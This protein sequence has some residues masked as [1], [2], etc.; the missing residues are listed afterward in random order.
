MLAISHPGPILP[1]LQGL[2]WQN[3]DLADFAP[4]FI[5]HTLLYLEFEPG[6][7]ELCSVL[8]RVQSSAPQL[9]WLVLSSVEHQLN[10]SNN[11][12]FTQTLVSLHH[13]MGLDFDHVPL[14]SEA[15]LH[16][17]RLPLFVSLSLLLLEHSEEPWNSSS[18]GGFPT[19]ESLSLMPDEE[20]GFIVPPAPFLRALSGASLIKLDIK[21][22]PTVRPGEFS[23]LVSAIGHLRR[24]KF[25]DI[26]F[27]QQDVGEWQG[28]IIDGAALSP[29]YAIPCIRIFQMTNA[30]VRI[31]PGTIR[32]LGRAWKDVHELTFIPPSPTHCHLHLEDLASF[33][34]NFHTLVDLTIQVHPITE[35]DTWGRTAKLFLPPS[36]LSNL[37]LSKSR[38]SRPAEAR[39]AHY[40]ARLFPFARVHHSF[41]LRSWGGREIAAEDVEA[42]AVL[43]NVDRLKQGLKEDVLSRSFA[44]EKLKRAADISDSSGLTDE[45]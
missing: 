2:T 12:V 39:V 40:L 11:V 32:E 5:R 42:V 6:G 25:L 41:N 35:P 24:L 1:R 37:H 10:R 34:L 31:Q 30:P 20:N 33:P 14:L 3:W 7:D 28:V 29:L 9:Q 22:S 16:L 19:L 21:I 13:L 45:S 43:E 15:L 36:L 8:K 27:D 17:S 38:I 4:L 44:A 18:W 23:Q 26:Y